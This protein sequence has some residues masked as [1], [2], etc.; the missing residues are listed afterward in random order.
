MADR[1]GRGQGGRQKTRLQ[2]DGGLCKMMM[3]TFITRRGE[4]QGRTKKGRYSLWHKKDVV[5]FFFGGICDFMYA[6]R[7]RAVL[8]LAWIVHLGGGAVRRGEKC[9]LGPRIPEHQLARGGRHGREDS[10]ALRQI[11]RGGWMG[12]PNPGRGGDWDDSQRQSG[13][14]RPPHQ[15]SRKPNS[16]FWGSGRPHHGGSAPPQVGSSGVSL[17]GPSRHNSIIVRF[18]C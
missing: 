16:R 9:L 18:V 12:Q 4:G 2:I 8:L 14:Q 11:L 6:D 1:Q 13:Y 5:L 10:H 3:M 7:L 15:Y 17:R